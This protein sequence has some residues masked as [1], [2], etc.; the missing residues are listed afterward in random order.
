MA[1]INKIEVFLRTSSVPDAETDGRVYVGVGGREFVCS[2]DDHED[3]PRGGS[4][5]YVFGA[6]ANV[7]RAAANDPRN[8]QILEEDLDRFPVYIR[9][10]QGSE[11]HWALDRATITVNGSIVPRYESR[12]RAPL[13]LGL[14]AGA[15]CYLFRHI[16]AGPGG[17]GPGVTGPLDPGASSHPG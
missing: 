16:D 4:D 17:V 12:L 15:Y 2:I 9:F 7:E 11:S 1:A 3:F 6:G 10:D 13:W 5:V 8:P 14:K